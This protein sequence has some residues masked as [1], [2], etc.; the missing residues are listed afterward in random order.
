MSKETSGTITILLICRE[1]GS[2]ESYHKE[3][4]LPGVLLVCLQSLMGFFQ[5]EVCCAINGILVDMPTYM[6]CSEEE[7]RLLTELVGVFPALR[8]KCNEQTGEIRT[9]PFGTTYMGNLEP[10]GFVQTHCSSFAQR[11]VRTS[12][13]S[14]MNLPAL[15][16]RSLPHDNSSEIR[17]V[18][19]QLSCSGCFLIS[20][21]PWNIGDEWWLTLPE[22][23]DNAPILVEI[24]SVRLWG[25]SAVLPGIGVKFIKLTNSQKKELSHLGGQDYM[26]D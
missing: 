1:G 23:K 26:L 2:R 10:A 13:R 21:K 4:A 9:L 17:S 11:R 12:E 20:F 19:A 22:L 14:L 5:S 16:D 6:R 25:K 15:L 7:K 18:T 24:R 3:L 8:L